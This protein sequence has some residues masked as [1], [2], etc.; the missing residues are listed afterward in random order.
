M[1]RR[2]FLKRAGLGTV[3][4]A[5]LPAL[6]DTAWA[7]AGGPRAWWLCVGIGPTT[8]DGIVHRM[9]MNGQAHWHGQ[10][11]ITGAGS[12]VHFNGAS[13]VP[14]TIIATG[15][16]RATKH[17]GVDVIGTY[18]VFAG[19]VVQMEVELRPVE[20]PAISGATLRVVC[21]LGPAGLLTGRGNEGYYLDIP[22]G[23]TFVPSGPTGAAP[24]IGVTIMIL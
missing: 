3:G 11:E 9:I 8:P 18:G 20:G 13:P 2:A 10:E 4:L 15:R 12:F 6:A 21:N 1:D 5:A 24:G 14:N 23:P 17:L 16:W 22:N 19:G 7:R